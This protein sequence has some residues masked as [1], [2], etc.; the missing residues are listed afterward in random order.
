[1]LVFFDD[2]L[3][4]S[5]SW[6]D[7]LK[8][9]NLVM[10]TL[11][12]N[13][14]YVKKSK[15]TFA[16][17][18]V[19]YLGHVISKQ[20]VEMDQ[21]KIEAICNWPIPKNIKELRGFLGLTGYY[22]RFIKGYGIL[23]KP[24]TELLKKNNF[25]WDLISTTAFEE[26]KRMMT[27]RTLLALPDFAAEFTVETDA[28][29]EGVGAVLMQQ[30]K[31]VAYMSKALSEK[32][33]L[34][35]IYEKEMLAI[36]LSLQKWRPYLLGRHFKIRTDHQS[37]KFLLQQR[38]ATPM[39]QK[40]LVKMMGYDFEIIYKKGKENI[41]ADAL[42]RRPT[43][44]A[45][46]STK[47]DLWRKIQELWEKDPEL[48]KLIQQLQQEGQ[49]RQQYE[50]VQGQLKRKG[51]LV[52][53][54]DETIKCLILQEF[55]D[56][57]AGGHSGTEVTTKRIGSHFYWK[58]MKKDVK[59]YV[60][61]CEICQRNKTENSLPAGLLQPLPVPEGIWEEIS[62]DFISG[63]PNSH[64]KDTIL[65]IVDR[66][67][68]YAHFIALSH[69][70]SAL[71]IAQ[72][73]LDQFYRLH[74]LPKSIVSDRDP[75]FLSN[76]W[77]ELFKLQGVKLHYSTAYHPQS[78]GQTEVV[79]RCLE[80]YLR[81]MT[82]ERPKE[83]V[84]WLPLAEWWYNTSYHSSIKASP[85]EVIY[86][87]GPPMHLPYKAA[88]SQLEL[89]DRSLLARENML[90]FL[91]ENLHKARNRMKQLA[92]KSRKDK[93]FSEGDMVYIKLRPYR[94]MSAAQRANH[95]LS[96]K[97]FG[98]YM[99][100]ERIG[101]VAYKLQL[102]V[103]A[104]IHDV[105]HISQLK[106]KIGDTATTATW[107]EFINDLQ[108]SQRVPV[109]ILDRQ[110][111]KR[112]NK[113]GTRVLIQWSDSLPEEATWEFYDMLQKKFPDFCSENP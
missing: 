98:P 27:T 36:V 74:G 5:N 112:F 51:K 90:K 10:E 2:I 107:P 25:K 4:Y 99:V 18:K 22:R 23:S 29:E 75:I 85:F 100:K 106:K 46:S 93:E 104:K 19:D 105:F 16:A 97:Y 68:K 61:N 72:L 33:R 87:K 14:L 37:L 66:M 31:P 63:L 86:G 38:I 8:H 15:C 12:S 41:V 64:G 109:A 77:R 101:T 79:N 30:G 67:S 48:K 42:S 55:H 81:C 110:L 24:L 111:V 88:Q 89:L 82:G 69:P 50:W 28:C 60:R 44:A 49:E 54:N 83:W 57:F 96:P 11:E 21:T 92:D 7:H 3:I 53:G 113:A 91:K 62:M 58:G 71:S 47:S 59:T 73:F 65:V 35:S 17:Q 43:I 6:E 9:L 80:Q 78:D 84:K 76:F 32:H 34:M 26:L 39:Q 95:K 103:E 56:S 102:P 13:Q 45:I 20:G 52:V 108:G 70:Y 40:W 1:M 94:Q